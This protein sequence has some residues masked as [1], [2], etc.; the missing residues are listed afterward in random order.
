MEAAWG[1]WVFPFFLGL[2]R[3]PAEHWTE[4]ALHSVFIYYIVSTAI[5]QAL[6]GGAESWDSNRTKQ[7]IYTADRVVMHSTEQ[8]WAGKED[9]EYRRS[10]ALSACMPLRSLL[11]TWFCLHK[12]QKPLGREATAKSVE[13]AFQAED[14]EY[15]KLLM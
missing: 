6:C 10:T 15:A 12:N 8:M 4:Q 11:E 3:V 2:C 5:P 14:K 13:T 9:R 7:N 1:P